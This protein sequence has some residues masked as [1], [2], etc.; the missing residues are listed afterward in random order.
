ML[1][2]LINCRFIIIIIIIIANIFFFQ[3]ALFQV[4][5]IYAREQ[6][7]RGP[8]FGVFRAGDRGQMSGGECP[9]TST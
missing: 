5:D 7:F 4:G 3:W 6:I 2:R 9:D 1:L 8:M